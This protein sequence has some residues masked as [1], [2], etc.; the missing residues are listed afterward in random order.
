MTHAKLA[1]LAVDEID[2]NLGLQF[3]PEAKKIAEEIIVQWLAHQDTL[4]TTRWARIKR[5]LRGG[6]EYGHTGA[7]D[8]RLGFVYR[9]HIRSG[10]VELRRPLGWIQIHESHWHRFVP[11]EVS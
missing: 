10:R 4:G 6:Y 3:N 1:R 11:V 5:W 2:N 9:R 8:I 7:P